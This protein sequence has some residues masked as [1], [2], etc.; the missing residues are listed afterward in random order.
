MGHWVK[1]MNLPLLLTPLMHSL[2]FLWLPCC[3]SVLLWL[4]FLKQGLTTTLTCSSTPLLSRLLLPFLGRETTDP[5]CLKSLLPPGSPGKYPGLAPELCPASFRVQICPLPHLGKRSVPL[6]PAA[7]E[8]PR[9]VLPFGTSA[10]PSV[11]L[12]EERP[13]QM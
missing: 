10:P 12:P 6:H 4:P 8:I 3:F 1:R 13:A 5:R 9:Y 7:S 2:G 11:S